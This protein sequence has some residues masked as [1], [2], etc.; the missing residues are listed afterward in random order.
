MLL[1]WCILQHGLTIQP[2][3]SRAR[4]FCSTKAP[5][6]LQTLIY[7]ALGVQQWEGCQKAGVR[8]CP[9]KRLQGEQANPVQGPADGGRAVGREAVVEGAWVSPVLQLRFRRCRSPWRCWHLPSPPCSS[10]PGF[11]IVAPV[12]CVEE[13]SVSCSFAILVALGLNLIFFFPTSVFL[14]VPSLPFSCFK[15]LFLVLHMFDKDSTYT[16]LL[17]IIPVLPRANKVERL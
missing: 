16:I 17:W 14:A 2:L 8:G 15:C 9:S 6:F 12:L 13:G 7:E 1:V 10:P 5:F 11:C 3:R 4:L